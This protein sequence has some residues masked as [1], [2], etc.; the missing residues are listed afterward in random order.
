[1]LLE[2]DDNKTIGDL[3]EQF[4]K[5]FPYLCLEFYRHNH[6]NHSLSD[7]IQPAEAIGSIREQH[8]SGTLGLKSWCTA[9]RLVH[10]LKQ[11]FGL[12]VQVLRRHE[13]QLI[14]SFEEHLTLQELS[15]LAEVS[16]Q[17]NWDII[18]GM[19]EEELYYGL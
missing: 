4:N 10:D 14:P 2:I 8:V 7:K 19:D 5:W 17:K 16:C 6:K 9:G 15:S 3:Q 1:M 11:Q 18:G 12:H 13:N